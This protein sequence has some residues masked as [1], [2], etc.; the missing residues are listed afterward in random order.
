MGDM[1]VNR[2]FEDHRWVNKNLLADYLDK[3]WRNGKSSGGAQVHNTLLHPGA[4]AKQALHPRLSRLSQ[5]LRIKFIYGTHDWMSSDGALLVQ[6]NSSNP[7][8]IQI[9]KVQ[10]AGHQ[11]MLDSPLGVAA[12]LLAPPSAPYKIGLEFFALELCGSRQLQGAQVRVKGED[13]KWQNGEV[14]QC[15]AD[16][17]RVTVKLLETEE[18]LQV[19]VPVH[20]LRPPANREFS[21]NY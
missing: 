11:M 16:N 10:G 19:S 13:G 2:R 18:P 7:D 20:Q 5:T 17:P 14:L 6:Q 21:E 1:Y 4:Y 15:S 8:N 9:L 3:L 12:A